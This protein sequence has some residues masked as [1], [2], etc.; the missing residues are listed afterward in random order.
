M[1]EKICRYS[2][3][4]RDASRS[5]EAPEEGI[6]FAEARPR[7]GTSLKA[8]S[9]GAWALS[10]VRHFLAPIVDPM[11]LDQSRKVQA[12]ALNIFCP[13]NTR[14][15]MELILNLTS[16]HRAPAVIDFI[17]LDPDPTVVTLTKVVFGVLKQS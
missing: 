13:S 16:H 8:N 4:G 1:G 2:I 10:L 14:R 15:R 5:G 7:D 12:T 6:A 3:E 9:D 11:L 17:M